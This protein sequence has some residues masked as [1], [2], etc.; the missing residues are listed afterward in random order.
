MY[1]QMVVMELRDIRTFL[2]VSE[3]L[4]F[5]RAAQ[6]LHVS[7][8]RVS[9]TIQALEREVG[10]ALFERTSRQVRL[11]VLG[12]QFR[13][14]AQHGYDE[15]TR[16]MQDCR[17]AA[18]S[19][20]GRLRVGYAPSIGGDFATRVTAAFEADHTRYTATL[21]AVP[22]RQG[23]RPEDTLK[24]GS[25]DV[26]LAW[27]PGGDGNAMKTSDLTVGPVLAEVSR[28][29]LVPERHPLTEHR[30]CPERLIQLI[31]GRRTG[32]CSPCRD[33]TSWTNSCANYGR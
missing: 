2:A 19:A 30:T 15:L 27:S 33:E 17:A 3:E 11:T 1:V 26:V 16:V 28:G 7:Q 21:H 23:M 20:S 8:G 25:A 6:R 10:A 29:L 22:L 24:N 14:G 4:H 5:G 32:H 31:E 9:Q 12:E 18:L 13:R